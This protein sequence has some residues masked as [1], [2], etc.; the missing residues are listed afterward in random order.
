MKKDK[1]K[2]LSRRRIPNDVWIKM[3]EYS[4]DMIE[5][6]RAIFKYKHNDTCATKDCNNKRYNEASNYCKYCYDKM[7]D[8]DIEEYLKEKESEV[9]NG[10]PDA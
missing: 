10:C 9:K 3:P 4:R 7:L 5:Q 6:Q 1:I 8:K 2:Q